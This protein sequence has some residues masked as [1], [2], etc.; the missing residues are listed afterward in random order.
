VQQA[1]LHFRVAF[2]RSEV[3]SSCLRNGSF[4]P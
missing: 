1:H 3:N 2:Q 4:T